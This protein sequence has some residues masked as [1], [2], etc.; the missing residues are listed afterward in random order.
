MFFDMGS[1]TLLVIQI[2]NVNR[3]IVYYGTY[4]SCNI[5]FN[6]YSIGNSLTF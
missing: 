1:S 5:L 6:E 4:T 3:F 2:K